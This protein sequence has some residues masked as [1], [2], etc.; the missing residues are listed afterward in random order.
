MT[1]EELIERLRWYPDG[2][3]HSIRLPAADRLEYLLGRVSQLEKE[4]KEAWD[5]AAY[6]EEQWTICEVKLRSK[7]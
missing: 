7:E 2:I 5:R 3:G 1:D 4:R 6:A